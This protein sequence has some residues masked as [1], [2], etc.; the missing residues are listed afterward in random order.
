M[1]GEPMSESRSRWPQLALVLLVVC[2]V[3]ATVGKGSG[4]AASTAGGGSPLPAIDLGGLLMPML[5]VLGLLGGV[6]WWLPRLQRSPWFG[7]R[8]GRHLHV[9]EAVPLGGKRCLY[10]A[11]VHDRALVIGADDG[12]LATLAEITDPKFVAELEPFRAELDRS[13]A[14]HDR[15]TS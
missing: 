3:A 15:G 6:A 11:R 8:R 5:V 12:K 1:N 4:R 2:C 7:R 13:I 9:I 10:L 14:A